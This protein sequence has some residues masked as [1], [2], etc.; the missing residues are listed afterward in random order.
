MWRLRAFGL[1]AAA[2][3]VLQQMMLAAS[4]D[5]GAA[6]RYVSSMFKAL[7]ARAA[8]TCGEHLSE[9]SSAFRAIAWSR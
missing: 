4:S 7:E 3:I 1:A 9:A 6:A 5:P 8:S 2:E